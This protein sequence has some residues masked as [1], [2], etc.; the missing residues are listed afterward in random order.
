MKSEVEAQ[1]PYPLKG[2]HIYVEEE[3]LAHPV[4]KIPQWKKD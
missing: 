2:F 1:L 4:K 3:Q